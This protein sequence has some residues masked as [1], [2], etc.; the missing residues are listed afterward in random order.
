VKIWRLNGE[1]AKS[2]LKRIG[3]GKRGEKAAS[4]EENQAS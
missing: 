2:H 3:E 4:G 1:T